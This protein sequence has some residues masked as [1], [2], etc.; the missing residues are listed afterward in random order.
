MSFII[1]CFPSDAGGRSFQACAVVAID[2]IRAST[3]AITAV[4]GNRRC[5]PVSSA[6]E[7]VQ[8]RREFPECIL[9]GEIA[10]LMPEGFDINNSPAEIA[11]RSDYERPLVL[12]SSSGTKLMVESGTRTETYVAC[13]RNFKAVAMC[14]ARRHERIALLGAATRGEFR[15]EDQ[16]CC[17]WI[18]KELMR[19][20]H[21]PDDAASRKLIE[22]W[23]DAPVSS[24][25]SGNSA[26]YL[27]RSG[28]MN[29]LDFIL[30]HVD[31]IPL[32]FQLV[33]GEVVL[34]DIP[35]NGKKQEAVSPPER[36]AA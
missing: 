26:A 28:Q 19:L 25:A 27:R 30:S 9:A 33:G 20:G 8:K 3:T 24:C 16:L 34:A 6:E 15:E 12:L 5:F 14:V 11:R 36:I 7:A 29:D 32:A 18:G 31:D 1:E 35:E 23:K 22:Q 13:L 2:V 10:G 4:A 17:G 21:Q